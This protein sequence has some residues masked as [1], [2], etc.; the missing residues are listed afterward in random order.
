M[1][2]SIAE[3]RATLDE[4]RRHTHVEMSNVSIAAAWPMIAPLVEA[5]TYADAEMRGLALEHFVDSLVRSLGEIRRTIN[6][7]N[8][9]IE[10]EERKARAARVTLVG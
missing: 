4:I 10:A 8:A 7:C 3:L 5:A 6:A 1:K 9:R 2:H